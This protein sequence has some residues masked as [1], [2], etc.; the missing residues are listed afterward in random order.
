[1]CN[2]TILCMCFTHR[3]KNTECQVF[4]KIFTFSDVPDASAGRE[5]G[6][7]E[8]EGEEPVKRNCSSESFDTTSGCLCLC[9][10]THAQQAQCHASSL[11]AAHVHI[12]VVG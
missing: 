5:G 1:M 10:S 2:I 7:V 4:G 8:G 12:T 11:Y 6:V 3:K 9:M